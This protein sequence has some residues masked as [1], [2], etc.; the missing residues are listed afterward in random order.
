M[1]STTCH[2]FIQSFIAGQYTPIALVVKTDSFVFLLDEIRWNDLYC[3][4]LRQCYFT[5]HFLKKLRLAKIVV[6]SV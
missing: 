3:W 4:C 1:K 2:D 5:Y 6:F